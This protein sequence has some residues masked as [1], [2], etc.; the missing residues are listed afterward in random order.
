MNK[1][2]IILI[3]I[4]SVLIFGCFNVKQPPQKIDYYTLEYDPPNTQYE[5]P[6]PHVLNVVTFQVSPVYDADRFLFRDN[7]FKRNE[8][9]HHRWRTN[10]G[11]L[12]TSYLV[13]DL[14]QAALFRAVISSEAVPTY[15]HIITGT[16][17]EFFQQ[18]Q[19]RKSMAVLSVQIT[20]TDHQISDIT[21]SILLQKRYTQHQ[22]LRENT[23]AGFV[24]AM[25]QAMRQL[26]ENIIKDIYA[27]LKVKSL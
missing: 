3:L 12:I 2:A 26:S 25:S 27:S 22:R 7:A 18:M 8:H 21:D 19:N 5:N 1:R 11:D 4:V 17:E 24:E 6:L 20:L 15:S 23:P 10:P 13:R 16:V 14:S 9:F